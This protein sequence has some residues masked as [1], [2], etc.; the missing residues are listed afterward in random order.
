[1]ATHYELKP[2]QSQICHTHPD[3]PWGLHSLLYNGYQVSFPGVKWPGCGINHPLPS[4]DEVK[5][6]VDLH[7][8]SHS[9][10]PWPVPGWTLPLPLQNLRNKSHITC[11]E[12]TN[13]QTNMLFYNPC[14]PPPKRVIW[15]SEPLSSRNEYYFQWWWWLMR[16]KPVMFLCCDG[17]LLQHSYSTSLHATPFAIHCSSYWHAVDCS[18]KIICPLVSYTKMLRSK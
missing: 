6:R 8:Y 1:M 17:I 10:P 15:M 14:P 16:V 7:F 12:K 11:I 5:D 13:L 9:W 4:S 3:W 18:I 2:V